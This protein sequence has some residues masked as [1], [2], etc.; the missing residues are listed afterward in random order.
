MKN[1]NYNLKK[2]TFTAAPGLSIVTTATPP[3]LISIDVCLAVK[4]TIKINFSKFLMCLDILS[5]FC[6]LNATWHSAAERYMAFILQTETG[7][8]MHS[9]IISFSSVYFCNI[10]VCALI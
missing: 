5:Q 10:Q 3:S 9:C 8:S 6:H 7:G 1:N 4:N 2:K